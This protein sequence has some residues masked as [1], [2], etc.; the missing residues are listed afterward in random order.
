MFG[1]AVTEEDQEI[2]YEAGERLWIDFTSL[3]KT[4]FGRKMATTR[5]GLIE[6]GS[7]ETMKLVLTDPQMQPNKK[8]ISFKAR[9][10]IAHFAFPLAWN[11]L[12][13]LLAPRKRR[14]VLVAQGEKVLSIL[15]ARCEAVAGNPYEKLAHRMELLPETAGKYLPKTFTMFISGI[16][17]A[18]ASWETLRKIAEET[19]NST[20]AGDGTDL[21][22]LVISVTRGIPDNPT[23]EMDLALWN[24]AS[25]LQRDSPP[26]GSI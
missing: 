22:E 12:L 2:L 7:V 6:P 26:V 8:G 25:T 23:T 21:N 5:F 17:S 11:V 24:I 13:N 1:T 20:P 9:M 14:Q 16:A 18:M 10:E 15:Q 19:S 4:S 3:L